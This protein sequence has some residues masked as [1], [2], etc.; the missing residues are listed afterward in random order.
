MFGFFLICG[1]L[2]MLGS[3]IWRIAQN[4]HPLPEM[5]TGIMVLPGCLFV[6]AAW[7]LWKSHVQRGSIVILLA[8][9]TYAICGV[10]VWYFRWQ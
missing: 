9:T 4:Q 2:F 1:G 5:G 6:Y 7:N 10:I 8:L 3:G